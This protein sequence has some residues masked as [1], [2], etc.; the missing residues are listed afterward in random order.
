MKNESKSELKKKTKKTEEK[1]HKKNQ[2][3]THRLIYF[4][5]RRRAKSLFVCF[6]LNSPTLYLLL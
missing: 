1:F 2:K 6:E 5:R 4:L 3:I